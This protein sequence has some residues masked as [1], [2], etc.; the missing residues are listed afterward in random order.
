MYRWFRQRAL[1]WQVLLMFVEFVL[2]SSSVYAAVELR[3][4]G[5]PDKEARFI[6]A[7]D[8]R[9][10]PISAM[11]VLSMAA[12]GLYQIHLLTSWPGRLNRQGVAFVLGWVA[13]TVLYYVAPTSYLGRGV[14][15]ITLVLGYIVILLCRV[16]FLRVLDTDRFRRRVV[17]LGAGQRAMELCLK[18]RHRIDQCGFTIL[19]YIPIGNDPVMVPESKCLRPAEKLNDWALRL[20]VNE[21]VVG[22]DDRRGTLPGAELL[23][24]RWH[25][26]EVTELATFF[27]REVETIAMDL[28]HPSW[29]VFA[30]GFHITRPKR[31]AKRAF[32]L[33]VTLLLLL[34]VWPLMLVV[35]LAIHL[36]SRGNAPILYRQERV[37]ENGRIFWLIKFRSMC[38]DAERDGV[39]QWAHQNDSRVTWVGRFIRKTRLD[40]LPQLWNVLCGEM[41]LIG[42]RPE[43]PQFV[44]DFNARIRYYSLRHCIKPGLTG[45][46]QLRYPY[47]SSFED[48]EEKL[49][50]DLFY[51][52][53]HDI[54]FDLAILIQTVEVV[55]FERG[56]R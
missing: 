10:L 1:Q 43:R 35:A 13:L 7:L 27:E 11:L 17:V 31:A 41:S 36:E 6:G 49:K 14:L 19:G 8:W 45:W 3:Y 46:A 5:H 54:L 4:W 20:G 29:L 52:K 40:E 34:V 23:E 30:D 38:V 53:N 55:L 37:G 9:A 25:G 39:A 33:C 22:P 44:N 50:F 42:P 32:D 12:L 47:G 28:T 51:V 24:C 48:A 15:S 56:A 26:I 18:M 16:V 2:L 21:I